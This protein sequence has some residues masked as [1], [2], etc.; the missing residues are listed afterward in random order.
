MM[1]KYKDFDFIAYKIPVFLQ[2]ST[3]SHI[4]Y[5]SLLTKETPLDLGLLK[6]LNVKSL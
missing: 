5:S 4:Y 3:K 1:D 6:T 2:M